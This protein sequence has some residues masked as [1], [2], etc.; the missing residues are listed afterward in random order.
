MEIIMKNLR[1]TFAV[2]A[3]LL[4]TGVGYAQ[5]ATSASVAQ[6]YYSHSEPGNGSPNKVDGGR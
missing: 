2:V 1:L 6:S 5:A 3:A 4:A